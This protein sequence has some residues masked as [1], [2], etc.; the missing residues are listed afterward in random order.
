MNIFLGKAVTEQVL[1]YPNYLTS[2]QLETLEML[3]NPTEKFF[4]VKYK[5]KYFILGNYW[6]D[7]N[8]IFE[9]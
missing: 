9:L 4:Q 6:E 1:P 7:L 5:L 2:E 8:T 3:L